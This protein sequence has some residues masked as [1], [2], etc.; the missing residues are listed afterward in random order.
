MG[1]EVGTRGERNRAVGGGRGIAGGGGL[2]NTKTKKT[3]T[4]TEKT[5]G[6]FH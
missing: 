6:P 4:K 1:G 2:T 5:V 3:D